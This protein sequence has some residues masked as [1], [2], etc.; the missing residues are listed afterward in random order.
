MGTVAVDPVDVGK[1]YDESSQVSETFNDGQA[2]LAYWYGEQDDTPMAEAARRL[3]SKVAGSLGLRPGEHLLDAGCGPGAPAVQIAEE[4]GARVTGI[5]VSNFEVGAGQQRA[6]AH[7][8]TDRVRFEYG[9][10][11]SLSFP[12]GSFDAVLAVETLQCA[13]DLDRVLGELLRVLRPGGRIAVADYTRE[14]PLGPAEAAE[15]VAGFGILRLPTLPEWVAALSRAGFTVEEYTQCGHRVFG[16]GAKYVESAESARD[17]LVAEFGEAGLAG[18]KDGM[19]QFFV[20]GPE[21]I[22]YGIVVARKPG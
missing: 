10:Y 12:D 15:F 19:Q 22:G 3:T 11:T 20:L 4:T 2:H 16:M 5:T 17:K 14:P 7:G 9:D 6:R 1:R 18:L 21:R 13:P 8:L